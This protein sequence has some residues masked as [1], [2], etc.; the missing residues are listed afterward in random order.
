MKT[1]SFFISLLV[2]IT[3]ADYNS[4]K[5]KLDSIG[6]D[7]TFKVYP[8]ATHAFTNPDA[9]ENRKKFNMP[10]KYNEKAHLD[11]WSD[12]IAFF[13]RIFKK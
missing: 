10:F 6:A 7:N 11:S 9:T 1:N 3:L 5:H 12:M 13:N 8:N 4:L 2:S